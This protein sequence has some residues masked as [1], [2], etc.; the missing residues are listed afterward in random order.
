M[1]HI[2]VLGAGRSVSTL[3]QYLLNQSKE[4]DWYVTVGDVS[5]DLA[6]AKVNGHQNGKAIRFDVLNEVQ[7]EEEIRKAD[8][9]ISMLPTQFHHL[10]A[11]SC[12]KFAKKLVTASYVSKEIKELDGE[13][14]KKGI[15]ILMEMGV[16][17]GIDHMSAKKVIDRIQNNGGELSVFKSFTGGLV[18][19]GYENNP[20]GY[21]FTWNPRNVVLAGNETVKF[22]RNGR[23]KY[24]PTHQIFTRIE[25]VGFAGYG[26]FEAYPNRDSLRY[27][28]VYN[29]QNIH[30]IF[31]GTLRKPGFCSAWNLLVKLG[32]TDDSFV[33]EDSENMTYRELVNTFLVYKTEV[34]VEQKVSE[35]LGISEDSDEMQRLKW[36]GL[37]EDRKIGLPGVSPAKILQ[38]LLEEKWALEPDDK[39]MLLMQHQFEYE[40]QGK[41]KKLISSMV[42][43]GDNAINTAMAKTVGLPL[44]IAVKLILSGQIT[45]TGVQIPTLKE[46]YEPVLDELAGMGINFVEEEVGYS[47][48]V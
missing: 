26:V 38:N 5:L 14:K 28:D 17:P 34:R 33:L 42:T 46:I 23:Y 40:I 41:Q 35:Y 45:L 32:L 16:D 29:L 21:K 22:I 24:I 7:R 48:E 13:A 31:R 39:D 8:I 20:W 10:V 37:F 19:P 25:K 2:L 6:K 18:A 30:T 15:I 1:K 44:G 47:L 43:I 27:R 36:L 3:I 11:Q 9:V 12:I 4:L